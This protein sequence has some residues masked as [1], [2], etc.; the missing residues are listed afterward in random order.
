MLGLD[1]KAT[2]VGVRRVEQRQVD[3]V[4]PSPGAWDDP[5]AS[6]EL[7]HSSSLS[8]G[9]YGLH[10]RREGQHQPPVQGGVAVH[11]GHHDHAP[12]PPARGRAGG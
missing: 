3:A 11:A 6:V 9:R 1:E 10:M 8:P 4:H 12:L 7:V 2:F 5:L